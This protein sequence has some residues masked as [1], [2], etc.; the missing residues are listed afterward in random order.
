ML[1]VV[2][3]KVAGHKRLTW[4]APMYCGLN[5]SSVREANCC[6]Q[7]SRD[8]TKNQWSKLLACGVSINVY[9]YVL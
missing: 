9:P 8:I 4:I 3:F 1:L 2:I 6:G 5:F 7:G